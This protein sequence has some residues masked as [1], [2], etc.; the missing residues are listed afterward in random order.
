MS[1]RTLF[2]IFAHMCTHKHTHN[3][4]PSVLRKSLKVIEMY[5]CIQT[6]SLP[7]LFRNN[8]Q[9]NAFLRI[10]LDGA[11]ICCSIA[12]FLLAQKFPYDTKI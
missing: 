10:F 3:N 12:T 1:D 6:G 5:A 2:R 8:I 11:D 9:Y 7:F 4:E